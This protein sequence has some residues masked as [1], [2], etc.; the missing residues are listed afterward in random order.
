[1]SFKTKAENLA[2]YKGFC[3]GIIEGKKQALQSK[4]FFRQADE[5]PWLVDK[6]NGKQREF[7]SR[8]VDSSIN[9]NKFFKKG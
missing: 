9:I 2:Y 1:M 3:K 6:K 5:P 8:P 7:D 4:Q